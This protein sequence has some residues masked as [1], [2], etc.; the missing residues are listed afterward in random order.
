MKTYSNGQ[1][2][3]ILVAQGHEAAEKTKANH[4]HVHLEL[5]P[6]ALLTKWTADHLSSRQGCACCARHPTHSDVVRR[7]QVG[8]VL[9]PNDIKSV[10]GHLSN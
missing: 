4:R 2:L 3:A 7:V 8:D 5:D 10:E 1:S 9:R 6:H